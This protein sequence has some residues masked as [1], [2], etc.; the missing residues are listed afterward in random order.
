VENGGV[1]TT[2]SKDEGEGGERKRVMITRSKDEG[3]ER[4]RVSVNTTLRGLISNNTN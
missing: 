4:K 2:R 1:M 3:G